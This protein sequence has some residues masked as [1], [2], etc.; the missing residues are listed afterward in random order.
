[1]EFLK[2]L[3]GDFIT[4]SNILIGLVVLVGLLVQK[5]TADQV[6]TGT[7]KTIMGVIILGLGAGAMAGVIGNYLAPLMAKAFNAQ[8][9]VPMTT[10][11]VSLATEQYGS[12]VSFI[13]IGS[14]LV[15]LLLARFTPLKYIFLAG[16]HFLYVAATITIAFAAAGVTGW[17]VVVIGSILAGLAYVIIPAINNKFMRKITDDQPLAMGHF[18][19]SGYWLAGT[20]GKLFAK[21]QDNST[22]N[23]KL[24]KAFGFAKEVVIAATLIIVILMIITVILAGPAFLRDELGVTTNFVVFILIQSI[25]FGAGLTVLLQGVRMMVSEILSAFEGIAS[26]VVPNAVP[27][28]DCPVVFPYAPNAVLIGFVAAT[29][30]G[31]IASILLGFVAGV[32]VVPPMIEFFFMGGTGGVFG[33]STGGVKGAILGGAIQ[34]VLFIILPYLFFLVANPILGPH[35]VTV[36]D[37][38]FCLIGMLANAIGNLIH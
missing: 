11:V 23:M 27:A 13:I 4:N 16:H 1:M 9:I 15:N 21:D 3:V 36:V 5:K 37:T 33:N 6:I 19:G 34:G 7:L 10:S 25:T 12:T 38:D 14:F 31:I 20:A 29:V 30:A 2:T 17:P 28:L 26:K 8:G 24:P 18:G 22:E 32:A 35:N